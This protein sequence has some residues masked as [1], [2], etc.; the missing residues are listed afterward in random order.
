MWGGLVS[1][2]FM[3]CLG[4]TRVALGEKSWGFTNQRRLREQRWLG[5]CRRWR[6]YEYRGFLK[7]SQQGFGL[8]FWS[9]VSVGMFQARRIF[10]KSLRCFFFTIII[11]FFRYLVSSRPTSRARGRRL[12]PAPNLI[13]D[14]NF[15]LAMLANVP[16]HTPPRVLK[17]TKPCLL[18]FSM[19]RFGH[20]ILIPALVPHLL[21]TL[22]LN[23][24]EK[25][26]QPESSS[27]PDRAG[28]AMRPLS[29][30]RT[31]LQALRY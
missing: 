12:S 21:R 6:V 10:P 28:P 25:I 11:V 4:F 26:R 15:L 9:W 29:L 24:V 20:S 13:N 3:G 1:L 27:P 17:N 2:S 31:K 5:W 18:S 8:I 30:G 7:A 16:Y 22:F 19:P 14:S 23:R